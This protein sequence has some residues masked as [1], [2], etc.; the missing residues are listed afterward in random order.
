MC[1]YLIPLQDRALCWEPIGTFFNDSQALTFHKLGPMFFLLTFSSVLGSYI[2]S[3]KLLW[4]PCSRKAKFCWASCKPA[5]HA[6]C[7]LSIGFWT[8]AL[9]EDL[10]RV[11]VIDTKYLMFSFSGKFL[12]NLAFQ[13]SIDA[14]G[15]IPLDSRN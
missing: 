9:I 14:P 6:V 8:T 2:Y 10:P 4:Y 3:F 11:F 1:F 7:S 5:M 12:Q 15:A 13:Q